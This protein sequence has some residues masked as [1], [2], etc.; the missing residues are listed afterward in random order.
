MTSP[1][2][3]LRRGEY[4]EFNSGPLQGGPPLPTFEPTK[5]AQEVKAPAVAVKDAK[6]EPTLKILS[7]KPPAKANVSSPTPSKVIPQSVSPFSVSLGNVSGFGARSTPQQIGPNVQAQNIMPAA[8]KGFHLGYSRYWRFVSDTPDLGVKL[9]LYPNQ[10]MGVNERSAGINVHELDRD[11][12]DDRYGEFGLKADTGVQL[13]VGRADD[14]LTHLPLQLGKA[15]ADGTF[16]ELARL[17]NVNDRMGV[18]TVSPEEKFHV[19]GVI[20][21]DQTVKLRNGTGFDMI[22]TGTPTANRTHTL[23]NK[24]GD[25]AHLADIPS[26][27][28][29]SAITP[30]NTDKLL[31]RDTAGTGTAE[32]IAVGGGIEFN[33]GPGIQTSAFTGDVTK[34][35]GG[36]ALTIGSGVVTNAKQADMAESTIKGRAAGAGT[37]SPQDLSVAQVLAILGIT[38]T[39]LKWVGTPGDTAINSVTDVTVFSRDIEDVAAGDQLEVDIVFQIINTTGANRT[40]IANVDFDGAYGCRIT[41]T[42]LGSSTDLHWFRITAFLTVISS[43]EAITMVEA[44]GR[45]GAAQASGANDTM[46]ATHLRGETWETTGSNLTSTVTVTFNIQSDNAGA[47]QTLKLRH[48]KIR[49][50]TPT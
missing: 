8:V 42:P 19:G 29:P 28:A 37:G 45:I 9:S 40:F 33:G 4:P 39:D 27:F 34:T 41:T 30:V 38:E 46:A 25:L 13:L 48:A 2:D 14:G 1:A 17:D 16:S 21:S 5:Q 24:D 31:G 32:E 50:Y 36:T 3:K 49:K 20:R 47:T 18:G 11:N 7:S 43:S 44:R 35:A 12:V 23:Q 15:A 6:K 26:T 10:E 22:L